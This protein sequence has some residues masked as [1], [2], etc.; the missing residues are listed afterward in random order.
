MKTKLI[1]VALSLSIIG[2][3]LPEETVPTVT[4]SLPTWYE[5]DDNDG[6]G[7]PVVSTKAATQPVDYVANNF[8]CDDTTPSVSP[9]GTE[10]A[11]DN[12]DNDCD[13]LIN[14]G[15]NFVFITSATTNANFGSVAG[16]DAFCQLAANEGT[17]HPGNYIAW[18]SPINVAENVLT[19]LYDSPDPFVVHDDA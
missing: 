19:R 15:F 9:E 10:V 18:F 3:C 11:N 4:V 5:D 17:I 6:W 14:E 12:V 16:A 8:D 13:G 7:N 2:G 1:I